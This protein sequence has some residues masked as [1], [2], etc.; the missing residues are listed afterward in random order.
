MSALDRTYA[1]A[2]RLV[3]RLFPGPARLGAPL[4]EGARSLAGS[5]GP[6]VLVHGMGN[7]TATWEEIGRSL[8]AD[9]FTVHPVALPSNGMEDAYDAARAVGAAVE[10]VHAETGRTPQILAFSYGGV[11]SRANLELQGGWT[12]VS[13]LVTLATPHH[14]STLSPAA[15]TMSMHPRL[16]KLMPDAVE[17]Q[18]PDSELMRRL[19]AAYD[20]AN[21]ARYTSI[22][23]KAFDGFV[24]PAESP[25]LEGARNVALEPPR[26]WW[27]RLLASPNHYSIVHSSDEA[28]TAA[29]EALLHPPA[30]V[31]AG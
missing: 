16:A 6:V 27:N 28:Y 31:A 5:A 4:T 8:V 11:V 25:V 24:S 15:R 29:R 17:M 3:E 2:I 18:S 19:T 21:G 26:R 20:P 7:S 10:Q 14:G 9:G 23:A 22:Y 1:G 12:G 30:R 13:Q